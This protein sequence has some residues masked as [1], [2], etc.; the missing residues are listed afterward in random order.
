MLILI[1]LFLIF[2]S[3]KC[4]KDGDD[5]NRTII[6]KNSSSQNIIY[7]T[8]GTLGTNPSKCVL[9]KR[10]ELQPDELYNETLLRMCWD[11]ELKYRNLEI[12]IVDPE[13]F[14]QNGFYD[15]DSIP[16]Y[17]IILQHYILTQ[18]DIEMLSH[19]NWTITYP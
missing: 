14:N 12:Y 2:T 8:K 19:N 3:S 15:C 16:F 1:A 5:C 6:I 10:A 17:N 9:T 7:S 18:I 13:N 4:Q 11:E